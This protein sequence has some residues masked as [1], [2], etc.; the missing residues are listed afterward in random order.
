MTRLCTSARMEDK[1]LGY[2][3]ASQKKGEYQREIIGFPPDWQ[4]HE[5][6][7]QK[8]QQ[9]EDDRLLYVAT[10]RAKHLLIVKHLS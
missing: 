9:A 4:K 5:A 1:A 10:T 8:Y 6:H 7:E 3:V 2:F